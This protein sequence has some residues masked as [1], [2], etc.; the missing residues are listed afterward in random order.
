MI[1]ATGHWLRSP[2]AAGDTHRAAEHVDGR[3][4][5]A[6]ASLRSRPRLD[7]RLGPPLRGASRRRNHPALR[8]GGVPRCTR[9]R[10][11]TRTAGLPRVLRRLPEPGP[12]GEGGDHDR[13]HLGRSVRARHRRRLARVGSRRVR[14][15]LPDRGQ[16][17]RHARGSG[18]TDHELLHE[19]TDD[20]RRRVLPRQRRIDAPAT[21]QGLDADL[22]RRCRREAHAADGGAVRDRVERGIHLTGRVPPAERRARR[23][24]RRRS[25]GIRPRSSARST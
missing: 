4:A 24:L 1:A 19:R 20:T 22:D 14:L 8:G 10:H 7:L 13:P 6:L 12:A 23:P 21:R 17:A 9:G 11:G 25:G 2:H 18:R 15:R 5:R 3:D 16:A